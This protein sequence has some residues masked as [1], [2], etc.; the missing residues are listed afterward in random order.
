MPTRQ[1]QLPLRS[2]MCEPSTNAGTSTRFKSA[3]SASIM[4]PSHMRSCTT[5]T[6]N[7]PQITQ[8]LSNQRISSQDGGRALRRRALEPG[9]TR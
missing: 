8:M 5:T 3:V 4:K 2:S 6:E 7:L 9:L 1:I